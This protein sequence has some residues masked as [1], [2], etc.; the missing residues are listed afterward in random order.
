MYLNYYTYI[1]KLSNI[2]KINKMKSKKILKIPGKISPFIFAVLI[3]LSFQFFGAECNQIVNGDNISLKELLGNWKLSKQTGYMIDI[4][5][6]ERLSIFN[7]YKA[8]LVCPGKDT[9]GRTFINDYKAKLV[10]PGKDTIGRTFIIDPQKKT[11]TYKETGITYN[12]KVV[13]SISFKWLY[14]YGTNVGRN[15]FYVKL[16]DNPYNDGSNVPD[17]NN[18]I[19][20]SEI[21]K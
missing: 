17:K 3:I 7:D 14:M 18:S 13:D 2:I 16:P 6:S 4:C 8:K 21:Q 1:I 11:L 20:S 9:I 10:C 12:Y 19:N 15:L 5:P